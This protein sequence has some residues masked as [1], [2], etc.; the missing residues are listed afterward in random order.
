[1]D[2][3][4]WLARV[5]CSKW[6][7]KAGFTR[8][9]SLAAHS[10]LD[11]DVIDNWLRWRRYVHMHI[12]GGNNNNRNLG[13]LSSGGNCYITKTTALD[14]TQIRTI[15]ILFN[16]SPVLTVVCKSYLVTDRP[17]G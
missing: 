4:T 7:K 1:M 15:A 5:C 13:Y 8:H 9:F 16:L 14:S 10:T 6:K 3:G 17:T 12:V 11:L 2:M